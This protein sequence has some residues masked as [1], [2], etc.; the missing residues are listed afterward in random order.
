MSDD[1]L[2]DT[3]SARV[4]WVIRAE[5]NAEMRRR[6]DIWAHQ[7]DS[8]VGSA[9]D[10]LAPLELVKIAARVLNKDAVILDAG[11]GTGLVGEALKARG[12]TNLI[13]MDYSEEMLEVARS[14]GI[15]REIYQADLNHPTELAESSVDC[16]VTCG[17]TSQVPAA[18][19][20]EY[21]RLTCPGGRII[22]AVVRESWDR[23]GYAEILDAL[24]KRGT[25]SV[26]NRGDAFQMMPTTEPQF[27]CEIWVFNVH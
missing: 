2:P 4:D 6:Y 5:S 3:K 11:A 26:E 16:V 20:H 8:D 27:F 15:Y 7:Y 21:A 23:C 14:K 19:L 25:L 9:E 13:A 24:E 17:T 22:F 12:F 18:S 1:E 10:Y